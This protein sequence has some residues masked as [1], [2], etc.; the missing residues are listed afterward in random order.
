MPF[1]TPRNFPVGYEPYALAAG[2]FNGDGTRDLATVY[3]PQGVSILLGT[4]GGRFGEPRQF[5]AGSFPRSIAVGDFNRDSRQDLAVA[6]HYSGNVSIFLG[7]GDGT[8]TGP[9][10]IPVGNFPTWVAVGD[11]N[12]DS[13]QDLAVTRCGTCYPPN[14][15]GV[16]ILLGRGDGTFSGPTDFTAGD[17]SLRV[18]VGDLNLDGKQ[19]LAVANCASCYASP[20]SP[21]V[22]I[23]LG[24]GDGTFMPPTNLNVGSTPFFVAVNDLNRDGKP[25]LAVADLF[26]GVLILLGRGDGTFTGPSGFSADSPARIAIGDVNRDSVPDLA[27]ASCGGDCYP[28]SDTVAILLG[29]GGGRFST[30]ATY[31][32]GS[33]S[34]VALDDL[35]GD[36]RLDLAVT[37]AFGDNVSVRLGTGDGRF[38]K[39]PETNVFKSPTSIAR[40]DFNGDSRAD[41]CVVYQGSDEIGIMLGRGDGTFTDPARVSVG[42]GPHAVAARD[43]NG[44]GK[45]D[46]VVVNEFADTISILLGNGDGTFT[47]GLIASSGHDP[48]AVATADFNGDGKPDLAVANQIPDQVSI[49]IGTGTGLFAPPTSLSVGRDPSAVEVGDFNRDSRPDLAVANENSDNVSIL[50][51][52]GDGSFSGPADFDVGRLPQ[53][54]VS[55]DFNGDSRPD[56]AVGN[57]YGDNISIL[58]GSGDG[59]FTGPTNIP[60]G[61]GSGW[62]VPGDFDGDSRTDLA[63]TNDR[64][65][66]VLLLRGDGYGAFSSGGNFAVGNTPESTVVGDFNGDSQDDLVVANTFSNSVSV[67]L[68]TTLLGY[69]RP[70]S[71]TPLSIRL[72]PA[73]REC[74]SPNGSHGAP[75]ASASCD[76]P[77]QASSFLT[78]NAPD[79]PA[80]YNTS[81]NG[82]GSVVMKLFCTDGAAPPCNAQSGDQQDVKLDASIAGVRCVGVSGGCVGAGGT[83][84]G[85][86][87]FAATLRITDRFNG[88]SLAEPATVTDVPLRFGLQCSAGSCSSS[89]SA[90]AVIPGIAREQKR[91]IWQLSQLETLDGGSDGDLV[92]A[93]SPASGVCPPACA[94]N[95]GEAAF[96]TQGLFAP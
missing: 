61:R 7:N 10:N 89:T 32:T 21:S 43:L 27:V 64:A 8:F 44:D 60:A 19:D 54:V 23:L 86:L 63:V 48:V 69:A 1:E 50:I 96:L 15:D 53:S 26:S 65:H 18:A 13:N 80:P 75:L 77:A 37:N 74:T 92:A 91:A 41:L 36:S 25:D 34:G 29:T 55:S 95:G 56:L 82:T 9:T 76:P 73:F 83:Y 12:R 35:N 84:G 88:P 71:A 81:A 62:V 67:L 49:L 90:D 79:R 94:G 45:V 42:D 4:G 39:P 58:I 20:G 38:P 85:K 72:V 11:F 40:S 66:D 46:L 93:P 22:S 5:A 68:N 17:G 47:T 31:F 78:M 51:G 14:S 2:D 33:P 52:A 30:S 6:N 87:L 57:F 28:G 3:Q 24:R 59:R 16:S 70:K